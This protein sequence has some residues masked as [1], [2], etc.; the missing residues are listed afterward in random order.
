MPFEMSK[1]LC[2]P[3]GGVCR[4]VAQ[5][6][7]RGCAFIGFTTLQLHPSVPWFASVGRMLRERAAHLEAGP[8]VCY[9]VLV[10]NALLAPLLGS[11]E[12]LPWKVLPF[13]PLPQGEASATNAS[14]RRVSKFIKLRPSLFFPRGTHTI[15][16]VDFKLKPLVDLRALAVHALRSAAN[17]T[18]HFAAMRHVCVSGFSRAVDF[19]R[20]LPCRH[21]RSTAAEWMVREAQIVQG[22]RRTVGGSGKSS[23]MAAAQRYASALPAGSKLYVDGALLFWRMTEEADALGRALLEEFQRRRETDRD[24]LVLCHVLN[25]MPPRGIRVLPPGLPECRTSMG[26]RRLRACSWY[27]NP[28]AARRSAVATLTFLSFRRAAAS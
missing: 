17:E 7:L 6:A 4:D 22:L 5:G 2:V 9:V 10:N 20:Y 18:V 28:T 8:G 25:R 3:D 21:G 14:L 24:Q 16:F 13:P 27:L 26:A 23:L 11:R 1:P 15:V 12:I 19:S